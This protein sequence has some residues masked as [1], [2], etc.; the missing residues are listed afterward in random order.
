ML[1][2][3]ELSGIAVKF[4]IFYC[5][6]LP[7]FE[8]NEAAIH[9]RFQDFFRAQT[10]SNERVCDADLSKFVSQLAELT[11]NRSGFPELLMLDARFLEI[12]SLAVACICYSNNEITLDKRGFKQIED[13]ALKLEV[14][15]MHIVLF[16]ERVSREI[17]RLHL[18]R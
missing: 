4:V 5:R 2:E 9:K 11:F 15:K 17:F 10:S 6:Q 3:T 16:F 12:S 18:A 8:R 13:L 1:S 14:S 7:H